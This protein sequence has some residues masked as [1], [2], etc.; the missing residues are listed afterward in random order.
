MEILSDAEKSIPKFCTG[1]GVQ[2]MP[3]GNAIINF[4]NQAPGPKD[5]PNTAPLVLIESIIMN[6]QGIKN[7][8]E[9]LT[10][11]VEAQNK[12]V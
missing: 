10:K 4:F 5:S 7:F 12:Q 8:A 11:L 2:S 3:D 1:I 6:K 9:A